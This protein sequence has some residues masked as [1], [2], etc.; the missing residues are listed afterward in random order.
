[1]WKF[2]EDLDPANNKAIELPDEPSVLADL[3][4]FTWK[5]S[6]SV[7]KVCSREEIV[8]KIGRSPDDASALFLARMNTPKEKY[9]SELVRAHSQGGGSSGHD[10]YNAL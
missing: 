7:I 3:T 4:A 1:V 9:V 10:P 5:L 6:G 8:D 2:R